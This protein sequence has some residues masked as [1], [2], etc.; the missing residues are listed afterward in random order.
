ME[1]EIYD[2]LKSL[3]IKAVEELKILDTAAEEEFDDLCLF[4]TRIFQAKA[5]AISFVDQSRV[6]FKAK[7]GVEATEV[8]TDLAFCS[9][10]LLQNGV[11]AVNDVLKAP[12]YVENP[13]V[14]SEFALRFYAGAP[15]K[16]PQANL[17]IGTIC[18]LDDKPR[19]LSPSDEELL[20]RLSRQVQRLI[21][22]RY[23]HLKVTQALDKN[24]FQ[25]IAFD[26]LGE[27]I[28]VQEQGGLITDF[29][30]S[31]LEVLVVSQDQLKG[32]RPSNWITI[33]ENGETCPVE[34]HPS[35][36]C[37]KT[38]K[39]CTNQI[40]GLKFDGGLVKWISIN[41]SPVFL[42]PGEKPTHAVTTFV[43][44]TERKANEK[45]LINSA[46]MS[47]LGELTAE[48]AHEI[49]SPLATINLSAYQALKD[50]RASGREVSGAVRNLEM[51][52]ST[53]M[54]VSQVI[55]GLKNFV[56]SD[57]KKS[58]AQV[59]QLQSILDEVRI[60]TQEKF[61]KAKIELRFESKTSACILCV[62]ALV[63]QVL[64]NLLNN[65]FDAIHELAHPW[66]SVDLQEFE[67][68]VNIIVKDSGYGVA[69]E[70]EDKMF[71]P[72]F[73]TKSESKGTGLGLSLSKDIVQSIGGH[74][75]YQ[76][77]DGH[78]TFII[79]LPK[80]KK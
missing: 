21:T 10:T 76:T 67:D 14:K 17:A 65:S 27:G 41:S 57:G 77:L 45:K 48:I 23:E 8:P 30:R 29:N 9:F 31:A 73:T 42:E 61:K 79:Q 28:V 32:L 12:Q 25:S 6:W 22:L 5:A 1:S 70:I 47:T 46:K 38:G 71:S 54:R 49:N 24:I 56:R 75:T 20:L 34:E 11:H 74:L 69:P 36:L 72:F 80:A 55:S 4:A 66:V 26:T 53:V 15:I 64:I 39:S 19:S 62:P 44:I 43:D 37:L 58:M 7:H 60:L 13:L 2:S 16:A 40:L 35:M 78:T 68:S 63:S 3:R 51:I 50:L 52:E 18:I 33:K 59:S